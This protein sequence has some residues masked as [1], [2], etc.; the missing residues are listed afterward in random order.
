MLLFLN[1][2]NKHASSWITYRIYLHNDFVGKYGDIAIVFDV[3]AS[4]Y[5]YRYAITNVF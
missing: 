5:S 4:M 2:P 3:S 1:I